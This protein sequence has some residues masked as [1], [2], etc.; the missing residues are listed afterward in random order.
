M[1]EQARIRLNK[2]FLKKQL[3]EHRIT[4]SSIS[5]TESR[6]IGILVNGADEAQLR[7]ALELADK[8]KKQKKEVEIL[9]YTGEAK[10]VESSTEY[11]TFGKKELDWALR[12]KTELLSNFIAR[13]FDLLF[14]FSVKSIPV[15]D[16]I[17]ALSAARFRVGPYAESTA[18]CDLMVVPD[19][20][21]PRAFADL[22]IYY[23]EK[24]NPGQQ[25][26]TSQKLES[27]TAVAS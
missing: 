24:L 1:F 19:K 25:I 8:L 4:R 27:T 10:A 23:L 16:Y 5:L 21:D 2:W 12:T 7:A 9:A 6:T 14:Y 15:L 26:K 3:Q 18:I 20:A 13:P 22:M 11:Q 17:M